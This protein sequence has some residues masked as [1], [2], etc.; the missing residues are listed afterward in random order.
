MNQETSHFAF[1]MAALIGLLG[2]TV[3]FAA[4]GQMTLAGQSLT[5]FIGFAA[6]AR[7]RT[8][9]GEVASGAAAIVAAVAVGTLMSG[10]GATAST[11]A[12][13]AAIVTVVKDATCTVAEE[14]CTRNDPQCGSSAC[15]VFHDG[16]VLI[17]PSSP[18]QVTCE[19][20]VG[21]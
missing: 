2:A 20:A 11:I 16:C 10:C 8:V 18:V 3:T 15:R 5:A 12:T 14:L 17:S 21:Q 19:I 1:N 4:M 6:G 7:A 9:G 13:G